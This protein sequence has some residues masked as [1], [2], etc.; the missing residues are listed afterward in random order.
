MKIAGRDIS[1]KSFLFYYC[2]NSLIILDMILITI[3]LVFQLP[4]DIVTRMEYFDLIVCIMLLTEYTIELYHS[5][6]KK[7][8]I[9]DPMNIVGLIASIPL[10]FILMT[11]I[12]GSNL[13]RYF[14]LLRFIRVFL[15]SRRLKFIKR[16]C[17]KT[18]L[19]KILTVV[20]AIIIIFTS[21]FYLFG[22]SYGGFDYF[23]FVIVTLAT[24]G[25]GDITPITYN[26]KILTIILIITG[27]FIFSTITAAMS[28]YL[29]DR[30]MEKENKYNGLKINE[31]IE[32]KTANI[33]N[34]I[35]IMQKENQELKEEIKELKNLIKK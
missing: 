6:S 13:L 19:H 31:N 16:F 22:S 30:I 23:Y 32:E 3:A 17:E 10:D 35:Q 11:T 1:L 7:D 2:F 9:L 25:Y 15:L 28:S 21:L 8:Y 5:S 18:A 33:M 24:V 4:K 14:R 27:I 29:T 20:F 26:E 12:P 34:E